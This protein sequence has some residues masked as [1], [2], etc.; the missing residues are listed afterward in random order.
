[1]MLST[2]LFVALASAAPLPA[3][4]GL[5]LTLLLDNSSSMEDMVRNVRAVGMNIA[6]GLGENDLGRAMTFAGKVEVV[7]EFTSNREELAE[8]IRKIPSARGTSSLRN[9]LYL[10]LRSGGEG[11]TPH[12]IVVISDG[13]DTSS[14]VTEDQVEEAALTWKARIYAVRLPGRKNRYSGESRLLESLAKA[15]EGRV[16]EPKD[17]PELESACEALAQ[18]LKKLSSIE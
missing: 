10:A 15:T 14:L 6:N 18:E 12:A 7:Q 3:S 9:A 17:V 1:M 5:R 8:A 16:W 11:A 4:N 2:A 13:D